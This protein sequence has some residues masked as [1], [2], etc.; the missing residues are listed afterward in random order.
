MVR[1]AG[2]IHVEAGEL[3]IGRVTTH[4][5]L[6]IGIDGVTAMGARSCISIDTRQAAM[7]QS[8]AISA[9]GGIDLVGSGVALGRG[10]VSITLPQLKV[11]GPFAG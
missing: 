7:P 10:S 3:K 6:A 11:W 2:F 8:M 4:G 9:E 1:A 5:P